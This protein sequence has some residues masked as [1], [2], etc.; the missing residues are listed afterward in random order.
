[1]HILNNII[2]NDLL[3]ILTVLDIGARNA[4]PGRWQAFTKK[5]NYLG[6]E[7]DQEECLRLNDS[8]KRR[9]SIWK[10]QYFPFAIGK[11]EEKRDF[12]ITKEP[13]CSSLLE[14]SPETLDGFSVVT[15]LELKEKI[16]VNTLNLSQWAEEFSIQSVDFIKLDVQG[17]EFEILN[18]A[19]KLLEKVLCIEVE[20]EFLEV[21]RKQPLFSDVDKWLRSKGFVLFDIKKIYGRRS[22]L[23]EGIES[24]GQLTWGDALYFRDINYLLSQISNLECSV[25]SLFKLA[26]IADLYGRPDYSMYALDRAVEM[27]PHCLGDNLDSIKNLIL[28]SREQLIK[29]SGFNNILRKLLKSKYS[30]HW[31]NMLQAAA[32][33]LRVAERDNFWGEDKI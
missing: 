17:A 23:P 33:R 6:F 2:R 8:V 28:T 24:N 26:A 32:R 19:E 18:G 15:K 31:Y 13:E 10:E 29:E 1:M 11:A 27:G 21:Y 12:Y 16:S 3:S 14:P 20:V 22:I 5:L 7:P 4:N 9:N 30:R 25:E